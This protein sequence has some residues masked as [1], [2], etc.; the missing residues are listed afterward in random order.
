VR[1]GI[2]ALLETLPDVEIVAEAADGQAAQGAELILVVGDA[3]VI[4]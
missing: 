2:R 3:K 4:A 1:A